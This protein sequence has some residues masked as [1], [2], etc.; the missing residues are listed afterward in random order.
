MSTRTTS[1][2][3]NSS[4]TGRKRIRNGRSGRL[5]SLQEAVIAGSAQADRLAAR[6]MRAES[7][8]AGR[9]ELLGKLIQASGAAD[10]QELAARM[11]ASEDR[12]CVRVC[13]LLGS[14]FLTFCNVLKK[15]QTRWAS[16]YL[17]KTLPPSRAVGRVS[18]LK[19]SHLQSRWA[20]QY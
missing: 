10:W 11:G 17:K 8:D 9:A 12:L 15:L 20:S 18:T 16:Q 13:F 7:T 4:S 14:L 3:N 6:V 5:E 2:C 1:T 19:K